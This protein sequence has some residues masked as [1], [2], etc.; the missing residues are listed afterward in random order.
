[1]RPS[2]MVSESRR[3]ERDCFRGLGVVL[4]LFIACF[5]F[6]EIGFRSGLLGLE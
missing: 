5:L 2:L 3:D 4:G 6:A 1:M